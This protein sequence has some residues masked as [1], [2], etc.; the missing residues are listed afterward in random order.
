MCWQVL[1][2][3]WRLQWV[4][5]RLHKTF[6]TWQRRCSCSRRPCTDYTT[7]QRTRNL[8]RTSLRWTDNPRHN[9]GRQK[10]FGT[11]SVAK[12][13]K[14]ASKNYQTCYELRRIMTATMI[15]SGF[16]WSGRRLLLLIANGDLLVPRLRTSTGV[17]RALS[18]F[19]P[20]LRNNR[21][22]DIRADPLNSDQISFYS[23]V[24]SHLF[25]SRW[26]PCF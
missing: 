7:L 22:V 10:A 16:R 8:L 5:S 15:E 21:S 9:L 24:K 17:H 18:C 20:P 12:F 13:H 26:Q 14:R 25:R 6:C 2:R 1:T 3:Q 4:H 19:G 11:Q 23:Y